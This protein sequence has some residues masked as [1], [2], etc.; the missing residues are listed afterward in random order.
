MI[1]KASM[2][3]SAEE[4]G[5]T[6][7][8]EFMGNEYHR[9]SF[10]RWL[11]NWKPGTKPVLLV[12]PPGTG[13]TSLVH[14]T[15]RVLGYHV[16]ELNASDYRARPALEQVL[17]SVSGGLTLLGARILLFLDE[18]DGLFSQTDRGGL[19][20]LLSK[21][22]REG[23]L[24]LPLVMAANREDDERVRKLARNCLTLKLRPCSPRLVFLYL[25][26]L[27][28]RR[29]LPLDEEHLIRISILSEGDFRRA[30]NLV[31][32]YSASGVLTV[33]RKDR[34]L[35]LREGVNAFLSASS[36]EE[37]KEAL[38]ACSAPPEDKLTALFGSLIGADLDID[39]KSRVLRILADADLLL[40]RIKLGKRWELLRYY[41]WLLSDLLRYIRAGSVAY[42]EDWLPWPLKLALWNEAPILR[43]LAKTLSRPLHASQ[44][45][46][47]GAVLPYLLLIKRGDFPWL[48]AHAG[49][50]RESKALLS[51]VRR[52]G[53]HS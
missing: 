26:G 11:R 5:P 32:S 7:P 51:L 16:R 17:Q 40:S 15:A 31:R 42:I 22:S 23:S 53:G 34:D 39:L 13:K 1:R 8:E 6:L 10:Y 4:L 20:F 38:D 28:K 37:A 25:K 52:M 30:L 47:R 46:V 45:K 35:S 24:P 2:V 27:A 12:G 9:A 50:Q 14:S 43:Q 21:L 41:H 36:P 48:A 49:V 29:R 33:A 19:E 18:V 3:S 44:A